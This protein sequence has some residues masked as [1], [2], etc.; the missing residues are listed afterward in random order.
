M[1]GL[2]TSAGAALLAAS[3]LGVVSA[4]AAAYPSEPT[5]D[6]LMDWAESAYPQFFPGHQTTLTAKPYQ[7]RYYPASRNYLGVSFAPG[8]SGVKVLG[9]I[10]Q[11]Q[12]L[13]VGTLY[14]FACQV[15]PA[16]CATPADGLG[17]FHLL[18]VARAGTL[19]H[20][21]TAVDPATPTAPVTIGRTLAGAD[22]SRAVNVYTPRLDPT[23]SHAYTRDAPGT[24][25]TYQGAVVKFFVSEGKLFQLG[26]RRGPLPTAVQIS[27]LVT[28][29]A[30][31]SVTAMD[32]TGEDAWVHVQEA[33]PDQQCSTVDDGFAM[34]RSGAALTQPPAL[35]MPSLPST[36]AGIRI[37]PEAADAAPVLRDAQGRLLWFRGQ[38]GTGRAAVMRLYAAQDLAAGP[39]DN[40]LGQIFGLH[41]SKPMRAYVSAADGVHRLTWT[42][43]G[44]QTLELV[45]P[46]LRKATS[47][48]AL[49]TDDAVY[50]LFGTN[51]VRIPD[52]GTAQL[53]GTLQFDPKSSDHAIRL[54]S[55]TLAQTPASVV[56]AAVNGYQQVMGIYALSITDGSAR[57]LA[58]ALDEGGFLDLHGTQ[59]EQVLYA[60]D[61]GGLKS[62]S[63]PAVRQVRVMRVRSDGSGREVVE[64][65]ASR[66]GVVES[67]S[68]RTAAVVDRVLP[69]I[70]GILMC[71]NA[72]QDFSCSSADLVEYRL[73]GNSRIHLGKFPALSGT[74]AQ[75]NAVDG[76]PARLRF[77]SVEGEQLWMVR[78]GVPESLARVLLKVGK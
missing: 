65:R 68:P 33:G 70:E 45:V 76:L 60:V 16:Q 10:S 9:P 32:D 75:A 34:V 67:R 57:T 46:D 21:L 72:S 38:D 22:L 40:A 31:L 28:A 26:L 42:A 29:C 35:S 71:L 56:V 2:T 30:V 8:S 48:A 54:V 47:E 44:T 49:V 55:V 12:I 4:P 14:S 6:Q 43:Q 36:Y 27:S 1:R 64:A 19:Q 41:P 11:D 13:H 59:G 61:I 77:D 51:I 62:P 74:G 78:P 73:A 53:V 15:F 23:Y 58:T 5:A 3:L 20:A 69:E 24:K 66:V 63:G 25:T 18:G 17:Q 37:W 39:P 50:V 7:Y 52:T